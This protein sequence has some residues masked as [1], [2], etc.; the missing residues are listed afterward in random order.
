MIYVLIYWIVG[1]VVNLLLTLLIER[2]EKYTWWS[3][4]LYW[5]VFPFI[6][7][8]TLIALKEEIADAFKRI[9]KKPMETEPSIPLKKQEAT[10]TKEEKIFRKG[11]IDTVKQKRGQKHVLK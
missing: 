6:F 5:I 2:T 8:F 9:E 3:L 10:E 1:V 4:L 11:M 7:P